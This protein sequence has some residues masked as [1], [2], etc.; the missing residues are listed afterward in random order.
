MKDEKRIGYWINI[1]L[2]SLGIVLCLTLFVLSYLFY[3]SRNLPSLEQLE[4]YDPDLVTSIYSKDGKILHE[5]FLEKRVFVEFDQIPIHMR[6]AVIASED[7]RFREH[8]GLSL[9]SV[10]RAI[11]VNVLSLSY[12]QGFSTLTQQLAR[13][14]Y[15][16][17]GFEDSIIRKIKEVITAIQ[18]ERTYTKDEILEMY[19]NT[20]HFGHGT[21]GVQAA[22]KRFYG[23]RANELTL[24]ETALLVGLLPSPAIYSPIRHP[25]RA[26][27]RRNTV[28]RLMREEGYVTLSEYAEARAQ[29]LDKI[30]DEPPTGVAPYFT[31]FV[32][33]FLESEDDRLGINI[34]RDGLK[35]YTT[36]DSRLQSIAEKT[37]LK[38][39][40]RNQAVLN[41]RLFENQEEFSRL[42]YFG[43]H[44]EDTVRMMM[45]DSIPLYKELRGKLLVQASLIALDPQTGHILA[46]VGG[47]PDYHDQFNRAVQARRQPGSVF[48]PFVYTTAIDNG[49]PVTKQLLNQPVVLNVRNVTGEWEKWMPKNYDGSTG[50]L[51]TLREGLRKSLNLISVRLVQELVPAVEVKKTAQRMGI[52]T[53]IRA[54][55]AISLG[56][57]EVYPIEVVSAYGTFANKGVYSRPLG[58]LRIEDRFGNIIEEY[59]PDQEEVL[60]EE[61]AYLMTNLMQTVMDQGT[62]GSARWKYHFYH[63]AAGKTGT[64]QGYSDAWFVGFTKNIVAGVW[65]GVDDYS[66]SL[67]EKQSGTAAALPAWANF[68]REAHKNLGISWND[69][70]IPGGIIKFEICSVSKNRPV[71]VC[72]VETE[73][74][75]K[76]TEPTHHCKIHRR[77]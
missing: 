34:Y 62:G 11:V 15:K 68:M 37:V 23:K 8:W 6:N 24:D 5:L 70:K 26:N 17:I 1:F 66:V 58:I 2:R 61:T 10:A 71:S 3:L 76:G 22:A 25:D 43:I 75:I 67:G 41:N 69:F 19:L 53:N 52:T 47:R 45:K 38:T 56:T 64:T 9:R 73:V 16:S 12:R 40:Q 77:S 51:T 39:V 18:I 48:K 30:N 36:L 46:M 65:F 20:V 57:S 42:A 27:R 7:R 63:P 13:N 21:F 54:V 29:S 14:L 31:E 32:R 28:L 44:P 55:D 60:S 72:P 49:Y 59:E 50:G 4:N 33:R 74:F 35:I